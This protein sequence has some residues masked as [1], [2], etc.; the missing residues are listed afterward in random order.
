MTYLEVVNDSLNS[1]KKEL[2]R[3]EPGFQNLNEF[4]ETFTLNDVE[5]EEVICKEVED[6]IIDEEMSCAIWV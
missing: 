2:Q 3:W 4:E 1:K 6:G 5:G